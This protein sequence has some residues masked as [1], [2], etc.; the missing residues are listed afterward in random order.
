M[1]VLVHGSG[2]NTTPHPRVRYALQYHR[3]DVNA[4][5]DGEWKSLRNFPRW[6]IKPVK[7]LTPK[8]KTDGH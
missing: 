8:G 4:L 2:P 3:N 1:L 7:A 5:Q 6:P